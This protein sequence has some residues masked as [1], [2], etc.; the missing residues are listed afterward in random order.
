MKLVL[1]ALAAGTIVSLPMAAQNL[2]DLPAQIGPTISAPPLSVS[3][4]FDYRIVQS[5]GLRGV[6]GSAF[7]ALIGQARDSPYEWGQGFEGF[8]D[9]FASGFGGNLG[10]QGIQFVLET[11]LHEDPRYFPSKEKGFKKRMKNVL[12]QTLVT[13]TDSGGHRFAYSRIAGAF[14]NGQ[15]VN[16]WQPAS[17]G[18]VGD[19][20][21]RGL[22]GLGSDLRYNFLQE[23]VPFMRPRTLRP[24]H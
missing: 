2:T 15:L 18:S 22:I 20:V 13:R 24:R 9:R 11:A 14:A 6:A 19:G 7:G 5:F 10:R 23:F 4:K 12:L 16:A 1:L 3:E 21:T 17:T 8:T